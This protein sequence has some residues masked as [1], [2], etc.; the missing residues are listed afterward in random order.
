MGYDGSSNGHLSTKQCC[1]RLLQL[2]TWYSK[3]CIPDPN[4]CALEQ[5]GDEA[6]R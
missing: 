3:P 6:S 1:E 2:G 4:I 5:E